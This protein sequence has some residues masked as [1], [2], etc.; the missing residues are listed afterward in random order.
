[1]RDCRTSG[2]YTVSTAPFY[3]DF[4]DGLSPSN[5]LVLTQKECVIGLRTRMCPPP[6]AHIMTVPRCPLPSSTPDNVDIVQDTVGD[7]V[8]NVVRLTAVAGTDS[9]C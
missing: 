7:T 6:F 5:F 4:S 9:E 8:K 1:M 3:D 2:G